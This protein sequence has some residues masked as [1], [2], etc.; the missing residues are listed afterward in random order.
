MYD[1]AKEFEIL[2]AAEYFRT[3]LTKARR[4]AEENNDQEYVNA[5]EKILDL[6]ETMEEL[7]NDYEN[8]F[9]PDNKQKILNNFKKCLKMLEWGMAQLNIM[10]ERK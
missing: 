10:M 7:R 6:F 3:A 8:C 2:Q 4:L 1:P 5:F 9:D